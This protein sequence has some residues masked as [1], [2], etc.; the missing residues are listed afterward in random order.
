MEDIKRIEPKGKNIDIIKI[1]HIGIAVTN[2][3]S[4]LS[5]YHVLLS[6][7]LEGIEVLKDFGVKVALL[8]IGNTNIELI[9]PIIPK[10]KVKTSIP[11]EKDNSISRFLNN[12]GE[13]FHHIAI[14]VNNIT[15]AITNLK[16]GGIRLINE[17]PQEG[18]KGR[19][20]VFLN[21]KDTNGVLIELCELPS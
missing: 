7:P 4:A 1:D 17:R 9:Q 11:L 15:D 18:A 16:A 10:E 12:R 13:G 6:L 3:E 21:P 8:S 14:L 19:L 5:I 2:I 20:V